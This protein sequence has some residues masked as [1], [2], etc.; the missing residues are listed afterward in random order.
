MEHNIA[1]IKRERE[2]KDRQGMNWEPNQDGS[3][4]WNQWD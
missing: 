1:Q 2:M 4:P 3:M